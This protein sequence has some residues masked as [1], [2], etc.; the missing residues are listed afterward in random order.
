MHHNCQVQANN[1][2]FK[3]NLTLLW[4][5]ITCSALLMPSGQLSLCI[6]FGATGRRSTG[7]TT[8]WRYGEPEPNWK[9][10]WLI[11]STWDWSKCALNYLGHRAWLH[12]CTPILRCAFPQKFIIFLHILRGSKRGFNTLWMWTLAIQFCEGPDPWNL[13]GS[14]PMVL[15]SG[16]EFVGKILKQYGIVTLVGNILIITPIYSSCFLPGEPFHTPPPV[17]GKRR[18]KPRRAKD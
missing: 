1:L 13:G 8:G 7:S 5:E 15:H 12:D 6:I 3:L 17:A 11:L 2:K 9:R 10:L 4:T 16:C 14:T 18:R